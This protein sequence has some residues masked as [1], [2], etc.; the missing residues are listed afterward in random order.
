MGKLKII[1][2]P[3]E[4]DGTLRS[5]FTS[6]TYFLYLAPINVII[7]QKALIFYNLRLFFKGNSYRK[8]LPRNFHE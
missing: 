4:R 3:A 6:C 2:S 7:C 8:K 5:I 1:S